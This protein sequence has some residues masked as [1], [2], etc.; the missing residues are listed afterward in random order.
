METTIV[1]WDYIGIYGDP[2]SSSFLGLVWFLDFR[3]C[4]KKLT[5]SLMGKI[6]DPFYFLDRYRTP[7][8]E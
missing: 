8:A 1:Y 2:P 3:A 7:S 6:Q 5:G 4:H